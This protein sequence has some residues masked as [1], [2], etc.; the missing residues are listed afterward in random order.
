LRLQSVAGLLLS[1][2]EAIHSINFH[3]GDQ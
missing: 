1:M 3:G 2:M